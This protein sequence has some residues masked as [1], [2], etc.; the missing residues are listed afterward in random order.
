M[1]GIA[2][3]R[4]SIILHK[5]IHDR[6]LSLGTSAFGTARRLSTVYNSRGMLLTVTTWDD[7]RVGFG[8]VQN[9]KHQRGQ[10]SLIQPSRTCGMIS[11]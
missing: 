11:S 5:Q 1:R 10:V 4:S 6:V 3:W 8:S 7:S 2:T 9:Q